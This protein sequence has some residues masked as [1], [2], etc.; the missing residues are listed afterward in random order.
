M[1]IKLVPA[2]PT[3]QELSQALSDD[4]KDLIYQ[5]AKDAPQRIPLPLVLGILRIVEKEL[6]E[7]HNI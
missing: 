7:E 3:L 5:R 1:T 6:L 4:I 2:G